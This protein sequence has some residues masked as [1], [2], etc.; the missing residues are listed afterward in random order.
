MLKIKV[1]QSTLCSKLNHF[2]TNKYV[3]KEKQKHTD[4]AHKQKRKARIY[5]F[6]IA[7]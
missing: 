4:K 3:N 1:Q 6:T 5:K 7:Q 2:K